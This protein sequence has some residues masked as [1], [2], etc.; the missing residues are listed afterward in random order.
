V[1]DAGGF[2]TARCTGDGGGNVV[3]VV[4]AGGDVVVVVVAGGDVVVVEFA[5][6]VV[7]L[8]PVLLVDWREVV[9][10]GELP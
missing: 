7:V 3:V 5:C 6:V 9:G 8:A 10:V 4:V 1:L 2:P